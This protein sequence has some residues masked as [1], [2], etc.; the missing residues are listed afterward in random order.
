[1]FALIGDIGFVAKEVE[2][3]HSCRKSYIN[4]A[5][6]LQN[7]STKEP[8]GYNDTRELQQVAFHNISEYIQ[9]YVIDKAYAEMMISVFSLYKLI[10]EDCGD[11]ISNYTKKRKSTLQLPDIDIEPNRKNSKFSNFD[12]K[13]KF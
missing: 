1:M 10:L 13:I 3:H 2:Y 12:N 9:E 6:R 4:K 8:N 7:H 11:N 5:D